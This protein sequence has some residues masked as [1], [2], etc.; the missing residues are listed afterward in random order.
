MSNRK[1]ANDRLP[2]QQF[3][4]RDPNTQSVFLDRGRAEVM[5]SMIV[6]PD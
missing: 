3:R 6:A 1:N 4:T 5:F 2:F